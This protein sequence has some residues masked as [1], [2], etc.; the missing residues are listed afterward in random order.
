MKRSAFFKFAASSFI[1]GATMAG[2]ATTSSPGSRGIAALNV[3]QPGKLSKTVASAEAAVAASPNDAHLRVALGQIYLNEGRFASAEASFE[4]AISLGQTDARTVIGLAMSRIA[5]GRSDAAHDL[6]QQNMDV[7]PAADYGLAMALTGDTDEGLR[8]LWAEA[9]Q[10]D[11]TAKVRQ[12]LAYTLALAGRWRES[13]LVASQDLSPADA[14]KRVTE[15]AVLARPGAH[16]QQVA[17]L[18]GVTPQADP[19]L[20]VALALNAAAEPATVQMALA[21]ELTP[22]AYS[23]EPAAENENFAEV[24]PAAEPARPALAMIQPVSIPAATPAPKKMPYRAGGSGYAVQ[25]GAFSSA[26]AVDQA[27][28]KLSSRYQNI[29]SFTSIANRTQVKGRTFHRLALSGFESR[30]DAERLCGQLRAKG[31]VCFV[32]SINGA[33]ATQWVSRDLKQIASRGT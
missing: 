32:R 6:L 19:G 12:N 28:R 29:R 7:V 10:P 33:A 9:R 24:T 4:D 11:A 3:D 16:A 30:A 26:G 21:P 14:G 23:P 17:Q 18:I 27:W 31:S 2:C 22:P 20:P 13:K 5:G 8:I 1:L 25:L 15:W